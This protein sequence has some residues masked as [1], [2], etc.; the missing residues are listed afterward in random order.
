M[1]DYRVAM[2]TSHNKGFAHLSICLSCMG[3]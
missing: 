1:L 3:S 2:P